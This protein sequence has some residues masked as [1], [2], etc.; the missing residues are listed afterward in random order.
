MWELRH[1][2]KRGGRD[3]F[4]FL[5]DSTGLVETGMFRSSGILNVGKE[6]PLEFLFLHLELESVI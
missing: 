4:S 3:I 6:I 5:H 1:V 2:I